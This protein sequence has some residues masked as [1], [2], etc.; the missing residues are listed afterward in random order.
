M[1]K[2]NE[3]IQVVADF[4]Q[5]RAELNAIH[6]NKLLAFNNAEYLYNILLKINV[7]IEKFP[8]LKT[9]LI[10]LWSAQNIFKGNLELTFSKF[11]DIENKLEYIY[12]MV[13][14]IQEIEH[15]YL[16]QK[17]SIN[18]KKEQFKLR[19]EKV[20]I[21]NYDTLHFELKK[22]E[23][24]FRK[25]NIE[26]QKDYQI[27]QKISSI[28]KQDTQTFGAYP[29]V[30]AELNQILTNHNKF[31]DRVLLLA[32]LPVIITK[33][34]QITEFNMYVKRLS[35]EYKLIFSATELQELVGI[36]N[37]ISLRTLFNDHAILERKI[38]VNK[39]KILKLEKLRADY[40]KIVQSFAKS[41]NSLTI[42]NQ[43]YI[44]S[45]IEEVRN[46]LFTALN[47]SFEKCESK[48]F[49]MTEMLNKGPVDKTGRADE[50]L[51]LRQVIIRHETLIWSEHS[52]QLIEEL[53]AYVKG[54]NTW[55][56]EDFEIAIPRFVKEKNE[57]IKAA[58][59]EFSQFIEKNSAIKLEFD[60]LVN[61]KCSHADFS[62]LCKRLGGGKFFKSILLK[63]K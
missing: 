5:L 18:E 40:N 39:S 63:F 7:I 30:L 23:E 2:V 26:L 12:D 17:L 54:T 4:V 10:A 8:I 33:L 60:R 31:S 1:K 24:E 6:D 28:L 3:H 20:N 34:K 43:N 45:G 14:D 15:P 46:I 41:A 59:S 57:A 9:E 48:L 21:N 32:D 19:M 25:V 22:L 58:K 36:I 38:A 11:N 44:R 13:N 27:Q 52:T 47:T 61:T 16:I 37:K 51:K 55:R 49:A 56:L 50:A 53:N 42:E 62:Q 29:N 35:D